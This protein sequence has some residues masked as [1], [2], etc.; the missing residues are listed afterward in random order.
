M[1]PYETVH[2]E[3]A[4]L[5]PENV[6]KPLYRLEEWAIRTPG[7]LVLLT[8]KVYDRKG[9]EDGTEIVTSRVIG[10]RGRIV[11]TK[12]SLYEL[13]EI[14]KEYADWCEAGGVPPIDPECPVKVW[15]PLSQN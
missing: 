9:I 6:R 15:K 7:G 1:N 2:K 13:G 4:Y 12:N 14:E 11:E 5:S 3:Q 10:S 8:G